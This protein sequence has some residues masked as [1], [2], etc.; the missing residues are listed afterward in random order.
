MFEAY[1][2][3]GPRLPCNE[4][5]LAINS[6]GIFLLDVNYQQVIVGLHFYDII[7]VTAD[8]RCTVLRQLSADNLFHVG[9][10]KLH[11]IFNNVVPL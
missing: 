7:Y 3:E 6:C 2:I 9:N 5:I 8:T 4:L 11:L 10:R 1:C